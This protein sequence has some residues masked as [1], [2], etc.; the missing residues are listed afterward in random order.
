[1]LIGVLFTRIREEE[2]LII[3]ELEERGL[4]FELI[5][6]RKVIFDLHEF[7]NWKRFDIV[8]NR[9]V[10]HSQSETVL[11][12]LEHW[13]IPCVNNIHTA[14]ICGDKRITSQHLILNHVPTPEVRVALTVDSALEAIEEMGYPVVLKPVV[15]SW[16]RLLARVNDRETAESILLHKR[17]LGSYQHSIFY[18]QEYVEKGGFDIRT[19][20]VGG[21]TI[22]GITRSSEHW[23]T[24]TARSGRAA[25]CPITPEIDQLSRA[26]ARA[27]GGGIVAIDIMENRMGEYVVNEVNYTM[28]FKNSIAPTGVNIPAKIVDYIVRMAQEAEE[29]VTSGLDVLLPSFAG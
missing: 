3:R 10:S 9:G 22:C 29:I 7:E 13:G 27:V 23:I 1:M 2:K 15:G 20:V 14:R 21:E 24:N 18:I 26:A 8:L 25:N 6:V 4:D 17:E 12:I 11:D 16:G 5:D 19:F 28:E